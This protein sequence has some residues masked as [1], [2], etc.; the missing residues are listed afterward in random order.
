MTACPNYLYLLTAWAVHF[1]TAIFV[2]S[3]IHL[4][5]QQKTCI[6]SR[7]RRHHLIPSH[8]PK[9]KAPTMTSEANMYSKLLV[10]KTLHVNHTSLC[11]P[12]YAR[13]SPL[14]CSAT[15]SPNVLLCLACPSSA[16]IPV[17]NPA[18]PP[19]LSL[20]ASSLALSPSKPPFF[21]SPTIH[22]GTLQRL[23]PGR[24]SLRYAVPTPHPTAA[25]TKLPGNWLSASWRGGR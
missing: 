7:I 5:G 18:P 13:L 1:E 8:L 16:R 21:S 11:V 25:A 9:L 12:I 6:T 24:T 3:N 20:S 17:A 4:P 22:P 10:Y 14:N 2:A 19:S 23:A 15:I